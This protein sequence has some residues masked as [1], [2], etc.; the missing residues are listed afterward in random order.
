M[1]DEQQ[2]KMRTGF[3]NQIYLFTDDRHT[4]RRCNLIDN[5]LVQWKTVNADKQKSNGK[6]K[7]EIDFSGSP[8]T[9]SDMQP[10]ICEGMNHK[11]DDK[12]ENNFKQNQ[13]PKTSQHKMDKLFKSLPLVLLKG[14]KN[15]VEQESIDHQ[16]EDYVKTGISFTKRKQFPFS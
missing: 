7:Q 1:E 4:Q 12:I 14:E 11:E 3:K 10:N 5:H 15:S 2:L 16:S 8:T 9:M 13:I 6:L